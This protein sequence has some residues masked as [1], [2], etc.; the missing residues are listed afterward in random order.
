MVGMRAPGEAGAHSL[1]SAELSLRFV[2]L[3]ASSTSAPAIRRHCAG[4]RLLDGHIVVSSNESPVKI[5]VCPLQLEELAP[6]HPGLECEQHET[7]RIFVIRP[8]TK[9]AKA[10]IPDVI[11]LPRTTIRGH[12]APA[13]TPAS[14]GMTK[15]DMFNCRSNNIG[16]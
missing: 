15:P 14:A 1:R 12:P 6:A 9:Y 8:A 5:N 16:L 10:V 4:P 13:W 7:A 3:T 11:R 2:S